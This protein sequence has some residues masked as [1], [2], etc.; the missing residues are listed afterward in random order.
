[1]LYIL[2]F[3]TSYVVIKQIQRT[4]DVNVKSNFN[5]SYVVIKQYLLE[6]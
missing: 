6:D 2:N 5:T 4:M 1:M 3:N